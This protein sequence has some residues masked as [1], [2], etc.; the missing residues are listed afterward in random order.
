[1]RKQSRNSDKPPPIDFI[2]DP[3]MRIGGTVRNKNALMNIFFHSWCRST[4]LCK[5]AW[6]FKRVVSKKFTWR[7]A[8]TA[9]IKS[10]QDHSGNTLTDPGEGIYAV[11]PKKPDHE[12]RTCWFPLFSHFIMGSYL[13]GSI[14]NLW[15]VFDFPW[16]YIVDC[17]QSKNMF[18]KRLKTWVK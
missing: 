11:C 15:M 1:M 16:H 4:K 12:H 13:D 2:S 18:E 14:S 8:P 5:L 3:D 6:R 10:W 17:H 7:T 9:P